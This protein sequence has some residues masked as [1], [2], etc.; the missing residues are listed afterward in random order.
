MDDLTFLTEGKP[1]PA[2]FIARRFAQEVGK[3]HCPLASISVEIN[4][5]TQSVDIRLYGIMDG[6]VFESMN[7]VTFRN[8]SVWNPGEMAYR[9]V[10]D[11]Y[12]AYV[13]HCLVKSRK[14]SSG[15]SKGAS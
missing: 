11:M 8:I 1:V 2:P 5:E 10:F 9:I 3:Y 12:I 15:K 4:E 13:E 14:D 6:E 7:P